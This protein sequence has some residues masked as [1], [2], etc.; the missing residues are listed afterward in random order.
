MNFCPKC[1][2]RIKWRYV[3]DEERQ[4]EVCESCGHIYYRNPKVVVGVIIENSGKIAMLRRNI[5][6]SSGKWTFPAGYMECGETIKEAALRETL[7]EIGV[8]VI[9]D[10]ILNVYSYRG[11]D[12]VTVIFTGRALS[13]DL[14][15]GK[16]ASEVKW[17]ALDEIPWSDL[18]FISTRDALKDW[19]EKKKLS[20]P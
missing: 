18:A 17:I 13:E 2:G 1:G 20:C 7:E 4:R 15:A 10:G 8:E 14:K 3:E 5:E 11:S 12:I 9:I 19:L 6:P 16:E